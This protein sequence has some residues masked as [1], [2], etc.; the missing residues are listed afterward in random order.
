M[1]WGSM[2]HAIKYPP[3][4]RPAIWAGIFFFPPMLFMVMEEFQPLIIKENM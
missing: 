1:Q 3:I 2:D 4:F